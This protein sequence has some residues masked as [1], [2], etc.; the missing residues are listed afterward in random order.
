MASKSLQLASIL[1]DRQRKYL[2]LRHHEGLYVSAIAE[3]FGVSRQTVNQTLLRAYKNLRDNNIT[4]PVDKQ[5]AEP[6]KKVD[7]PTLRVVNLGY[8]D[9]ITGG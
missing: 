8:I 3:N 4:P 9:E 7:G 2:V 5:D 1:T 6:E